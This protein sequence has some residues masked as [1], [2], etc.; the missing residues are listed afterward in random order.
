[1]TAAASFAESDDDA[2]TT[3]TSRYESL[4]EMRRDSWNDHDHHQEDQGQQDSKQEADVLSS[5]SS[6]DDEVDQED[7]TNI[8]R[9]LQKSCEEE[10]Q[11]Y[12]QEEDGEQTLQQSTPQK[13]PL[14][15][16]PVSNANNNATSEALIDPETLPDLPLEIGD[17]V[18]QWRSFAGIPGV[19]QHHGIVMDCT[20]DEAGDGY[21]L[22]IADFSCILRAPSSTTKKHSPNDSTRIQ[23]T[24]SID[25]ITGLQLED[26]VPFALHPHGVLRVYNSTSKDPKWHKV[27]YRASVWKTSLWR[28]GTCTCVPS[29]P[30]GKVLARCYF[31][32]ENPQLLPPYHIFRSNCEC[33][34]LWCKTGQWMTLQAS[35]LLSL[36]AAGQLKST[37]TIA[38]YAA[39]QT[40][41][42]S[43][44]AA[45]IW[46]YLGY[47]TST[48]VSLLTTQPH[49]VPL[50]A[51]YGVVTAG[52]PTFVLWRANKF[53]DKTTERLNEEF[54]NHALKD[55]DFFAQSL[56]H[57]SEKHKAFER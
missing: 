47:T 2:M 11:R 54:W 8:E 25:M 37:A 23:R 18:Y 28:S 55:P 7:D 44:P 39:S 20:R 49:L 3:T 53:W 34:S 4:H 46:G 48:Q 31:L 51:A 19:F 1:M 24:Q 15:S 17:H 26:K 13:T 36:T 16:I 14:D 33:V 12:L 42:V 38:A 5:C 6:S 57:W 52:G 56:F 30:P 40:T 10:I 9:I 45:G 41:T 32:M 27:L 22:Q 35:S 29:D 50:L 21:E 43:A